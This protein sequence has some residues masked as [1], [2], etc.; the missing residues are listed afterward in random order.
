MAI[1]SSIY[2]GMNLVAKEYMASQVDENGVLL[3]SEFAGAAEAIPGAM[4]INP[5]DTEHFADAIRDALQMPASEKKK[6]VRAAVGYL[7]EY[8]IYKW[9]DNVLEEAEKLR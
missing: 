6:A 2:D 7:R 4:L 8:T 5:Y 3:L 9:V 1:V